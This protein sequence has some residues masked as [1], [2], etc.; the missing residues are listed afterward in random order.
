MYVHDEVGERLIVSSGA[1]EAHASSS[2]SLSNTL[3][4]VILTVLYLAVISIS[5]G[6]HLWL[7]ELLTYHLAN[8]PTIRE[9]FRAAWRFDLNPP[10]FHLLARAGFW[11]AGG[12]P[13]GVRFPSVVE[14][15]L[16]GVLLFFY[17]RR[18]MGPLFGALPVLLLWYGPMSQFATEAR[19]Y[20]ALCFWF[21]ALLLLWDTAIHQSERR[22][23]L[24]LAIAVC[25]T[26]LLTSHVFGTLT[27][28]A[29]LCAEAVRFYATRR[30]DWPLWAALFAPMA[31]T[32]FYIP[33][34]VSYGRAG[35][36]P[37]DF[38]ASPRKLAGF[39][40][41]NFTGV[42]LCFGVMALA[43]V[44]A[45][46]RPVAVSS[47]R[48]REAVSAPEFILFAAQALVPVLLTAVFML[49]HG[50]FWGRY[51]ITSLIALYFL[52]SY[53]LRVV[54][55][56]S[57]DAGQWAFW[58]ASVLVFAHGFV[59]P[60]WRQ[61][62]D[63]VPAS[64]AALENVR[65]ELPLAAASGLT[66]IEMGQYESPRL[67]DRLYYLQD[68][69]AALRIAHA[70]MFNDLADIQQR[71]HLP[72]HVVPYASFMRDH[73]DFL[74]L[75]TPGYPEDWLVRKLEEDGARVQ[76]IGRYQI[77]YKD[78]QLFEVQP[79]MSR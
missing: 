8:L 52:A 73:K 42:V 55:N 44:A 51:C 2:K 45:R 43:V 75:A 9:M 20:A 39:Y 31:L 79:R 12:N 30:P 32:A 19:P 38:Q 78:T 47:A 4:L 18:K 3:I 16:S 10:L 69:S 1:V 68:Q 63:P 67:L 70:S 15:F 48:K 11:F 6:R 5:I 62:T 58:A 59:W 37:L 7:D 77:P 76:P 22:G 34:F 23:T 35:Q 24:W 17:A 74:V 50:A 21:C 26:G 66:F 41:N 54:A 53:A 49:Q 36:F 14:F 61:T 71:F 65:P 25:S 40:W 57:D 13:I 28:F 27:I 33:L 46:R 72:G 60:L 29:F 64:A 56:A